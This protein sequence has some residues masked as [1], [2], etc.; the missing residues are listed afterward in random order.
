MS[1]LVSL[2]DA[3]DGTREQYQKGDDNGSA[4]VRPVS[5]V[6]AVFG[7]TMQAASSAAAPAG[8]DEY[9]S[10]GAGWKLLEFR[11]MTDIAAP[12]Q[13]IIGWSTTADD[14]S[15]AVNL[16][17]R[18]AG[19]VQGEAEYPNQVSMTDGVPYAVIPW[20]GVTTIKTFAITHSAAS[21]VLM[22]VMLVY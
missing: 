5:A 22:S 3:R 12:N 21:A 20:D 17:A 15:V 18:V 6:G 8:Q 1:G 11:N 16:A 7:C 10:N 9:K 19:A 14:T 2:I 4:Y 13:V